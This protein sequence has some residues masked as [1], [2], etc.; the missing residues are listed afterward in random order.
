MNR[1]DFVL[2]VNKYLGNEYSPKSTRKYLDAIIETICRELYLTGK[3]FIQDFGSF[4]LTHYQ[5]KYMNTNNGGIYK[6][7]EHDY[8]KFRPAD[9]FING[10]NCFGVTARYKKRARE[11]KLNSNDKKMLTN[12]RLFESMKKITEQEKQS[13][14][15]NFADELKKV[16]KEFKERNKEKEDELLDESSDGNEEV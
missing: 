14:K 7:P 8:P 3:C 5:E 16:S 15:D 1:D 12:Q 13:V 2:L 11:N 10:V 9:A 6:V 4:S